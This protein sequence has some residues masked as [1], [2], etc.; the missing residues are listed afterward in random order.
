M[1]KKRVLP[2]INDG[3]CVFLYELL[4]KSKKLALKRRWNIQVNATGDLD[5]VDIFVCNVGSNLSWLE[6][7]W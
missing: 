7:S 4:K 2:D 6:P 3:F 1:S 5:S